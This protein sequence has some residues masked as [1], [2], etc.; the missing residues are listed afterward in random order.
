MGAYEHWL[1]SQ[2]KLMERIGEVSGQEE[3]A[4][5]VRHALAQVEQNT[6]AEQ[7]D[8]LLRQQLGI[9]FSCCKT[10]VNLLS[11]SVLPKVWMAETQPSK[12]NKAQTMLW[13]V[14]GCLQ[15]AVGFYCYTM[16]LTLVWMMLIA[17]LALGGVAVFLWKKAQ[18]KESFA[19]RYKVT[20]SPDVSKLSHAIDVQMQAID[21]YMNDFIYLN[22]QQ[23]SLPKLPDHKM[24]EHISNMMEALYACGGGATEAREAAGKMLAQ[25][26]INEIEYTKEHERLFTMLPSKTVTRTIV[27]A[28]VASESFELLHLG[29][30]AVQQ[31][32]SK[33]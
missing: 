22:E 11:I 33:E 20:M 27:P 10:A 28:L 30:A 7:E 1:K 6:M 32:D 24:L 23:G 9:L 17:S 18:K 25:F 31:P 12:R 14:A 13:I 21:R 2:P 5:A 26:G 16:Q 29:V 3:M 19:D 15:G 4:Y 8:D